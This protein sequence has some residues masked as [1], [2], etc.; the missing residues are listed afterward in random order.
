[1]TY[2][3]LIVRIKD[4]IREYDPNIAVDEASAIRDLLIDPSAIIM[5]PEIDDMET[6][7]TNSSLLNY[8]DMDQAA[9]DKYAGNFIVSRRTGTKATGTLRLY[10]L[11]PL[12]ISIPAGTVFV[13]TE[14]LINY[15]APVEY[16]FSDVT[17]SQ[18]VEGY[19]LYVDVQVDA[20]EEGLNSNADAGA[21]FAFDNISNSNV[22]TIK[23]YSTISGGTH[24]E[25]NEELY[26]R[27]K[28][29]ITKRDLISQRGANT[30]L[31]EQFPQIKRITI[32]GKDDPEMLRDAYPP[33]PNPISIH[34]G[35][36]IDYY[37]TTA[38]DNPYGET[39]IQD[40][41]IDTPMGKGRAINA[42]PI[43]RIKDIELVDPLSGSPLGTYIP[44]D[45]YSIFVEDE[46]FR[47]SVDEAC[48]LHLTN[49]IWEHSA[50]K[51]NYQYNPDASS[52][53]AYTKSL[54]NRTINANPEV[55]N[56]KP[57]FISFIFNFVG[58]PTEDE[59]RAAIY[60]YLLYPLVYDINDVPYNNLT[61]DSK[62]YIKVT[63]IVDLAKDLG[64]L[65]VDLPIT[66]T[67]LFYE[68]DGTIHTETSVD[69]ILIERTYAFYPDNIV[70]LRRDVE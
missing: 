49:P 32:I 62:I 15:V 34:V 19:Y 13:N 47:F 18:Q 26:P 1:M 60:N 63:D 20:V 51:I 39:L 29:G 54:D 2:Q 7:K 22:V 9:M 27:I 25:T 58:G 21:V 53:L 23:S 69:K 68:Q 5:K 31:F 48:M 65:H 70:I 67:A 37:I 45:D 36:M 57:V 33:P 14:S 17:V 12:P 66:L 41:Q 52:V 8:A 59:V 40:L 38:E 10:L 56:H 50:A 64:A 30:I 44:E 3:E 6:L 4:L 11:N 16:Y 55:F 24:Q 61:A 46:W 35:G 42:A 28:D 43:L